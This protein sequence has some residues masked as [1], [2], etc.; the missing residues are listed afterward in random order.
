[1][2]QNRA[3]VERGTVERESVKVISSVYISRLNLK[4]SEVM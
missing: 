1:M 3:I 4:L 2:K